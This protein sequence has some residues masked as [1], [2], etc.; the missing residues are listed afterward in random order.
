[1]PTQDLDN[2]LDIIEGL[3]EEE[4]NQKKVGDLSQLLELLKCTKDH[5]TQ[6][7]TFDSFTGT[8]DDDDCSGYLQVW[9]FNQGG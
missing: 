7:I 2:A 4:E 6:S 3:L 1:M 8:I 5:V 9:I